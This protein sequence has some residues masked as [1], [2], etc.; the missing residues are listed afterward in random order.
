MCASYFGLYGIPWDI[1]HKKL[2]PT[3]PFLNEAHKL[4]SC[5]QH[6]LSVA[7]FCHVCSG[8]YARRAK[9]SPQCH[10]NGAI[11][12]FKQRSFIQIRVKSLKWLAFICSANNHIIIFM[13]RSSDIIV[14]KCNLL[15][16]SHRFHFC[17]MH[18]YSKVWYCFIYLLID[19]WSSSNASKCMDLYSAYRL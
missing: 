14:V 16:F 8:E 13:T 15:A 18:C 10:F 6:G 1:F 17:W 4:G 9:L 3:A 7:S 2:F 5:A 12:G 19:R 11:N